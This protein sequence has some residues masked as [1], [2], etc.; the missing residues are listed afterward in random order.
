MRRWLRVD[1]QWRLSPWT[2]DMAAQ[3]DVRLV[4]TQ[5]DW[6]RR[7]FQLGSIRGK[8]SSLLLIAALV[9]YF[10]GATELSQFL[11]L[12]QFFCHVF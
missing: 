1:C 4:C 6:E 9:R 11:A 12:P 10:F 2:L 7:S 3:G 5:P 8:F